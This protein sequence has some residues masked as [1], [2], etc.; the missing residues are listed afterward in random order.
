MSV[1]PPVEA[2]REAV[3]RALTEDTSPL[4]DITASLIPADAIAMFAVAT[5][6]AGVVAGAMCA[7]EA[8]ARTDPRILVDWLV[9]DGHTVIAGERLGIVEGPLAPILTA[10]RTA[11]NFLCHLSGIATTARAFVEAARGANPATR[12]LDTRKTT[13]GLRS[14]EKAAVRAGGAHNHRGNLSEAVMIKDN[15][16]AGLG[17]REAVSMAR[18]MWPGRMIE[19]E[20]EDLVQVEEAVESGATVVMLDNMGPNGVSDAV[21]LIAERGQSGR[22]L[23]EVSGGVTL[24]TVPEFARAGA[25][26]IS[27]GAITHSAHALDIGLDLVQRD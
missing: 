4:G 14:L 25:D 2:V 10:E 8:F 19:V 20:C 7:I 27:A 26:L 6:A 16:L 21:K 12:I 22:V 17:I 24:E 11:L 13:P 15:H 23:T 9:P 18:R 3:S 1:E 5:R